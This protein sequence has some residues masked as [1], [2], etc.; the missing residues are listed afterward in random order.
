MQLFRDRNE[1]TKMTKFHRKYI[2]LNLI[3][4]HKRINDTARLRLDDDAAEARP[5]ARVKVYCVQGIGQHYR[6][7]L[8]KVTVGVEDCI[9]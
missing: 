9:E 3:N 4:I 8:R 6:D 1:V 7:M 5:R 2:S